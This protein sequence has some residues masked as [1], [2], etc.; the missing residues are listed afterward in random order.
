M[1][2]CREE[3]A[4]RSGRRAMVWL[5]G[6]LERFDPMVPTLTNKVALRDLSTLQI[7]HAGFKVY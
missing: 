3:R 4:T 7:H 5:D 1:P 2:R 6:P